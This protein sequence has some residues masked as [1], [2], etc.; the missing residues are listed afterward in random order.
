MAMTKEQETEIITDAIKHPGFKLIMQKLADAAEKAQSR[1]DSSQD[2]DEVIRIQTLRM[3]CLKEIPRIIEE[4]ANV[5][6]PKDGR[7]KFWEWLKK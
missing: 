7:W 5:D 3:I 4:M 1:Y 6:T 2:H